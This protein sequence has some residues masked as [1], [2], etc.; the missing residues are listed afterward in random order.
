MQ[1]NPTLS[2]VAQC[3]TSV[4]NKSFFNPS[5]LFLVLGGG[6]DDADDSPNSGESN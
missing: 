4:L 1:S 6:D 5:S 3:T 2:F